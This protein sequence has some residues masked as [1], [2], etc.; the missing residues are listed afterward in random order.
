MSSDTLHLLDLPRDIIN[1]ILLRLDLDTINNIGKTCTT[2]QD[3][4]DEFKKSHKEFIARKML[5]RKV[6][7]LVAGDEDSDDDYDDYG[8]ESDNDVDDIQRIVDEFN[9]RLSCGSNYDEEIDEYLNQ[10]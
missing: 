8:Q 4:V 1:E 7:I 9:D 5:E 10:R 6:R 3:Q 2:L